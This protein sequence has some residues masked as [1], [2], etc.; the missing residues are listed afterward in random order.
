M[1]IP[2]LITLMRAILVPV[3][4][5]L[6][7]AGYIKAAF[8]VFVIA[9]VSDGIDGLL[10]RRFNWQTELGAYLDPL[11]D[12]LLIVSIFL[13]LGVRGDLPSWLVVAVVSRDLLILL[14]IIVSWLLNKPIKIDP[15]AVSKATTF[16]QLALAALVLADEGFM[17]NVGAYRQGLVWVTAV[18]TILSLAAYLRSWLVHMSR[19]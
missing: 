15:L 11:A 16:A 2:N 7:L 12:K 10:A 19:D 14:A 6:L 17:L 4:F 3:V 13:A 1:T 5:W 9:G 8:V 18:L